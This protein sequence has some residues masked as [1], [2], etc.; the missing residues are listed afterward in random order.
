MNKKYNLDIF[1]NNISTLKDTSIDKSPDSN[2]IVTIEYM[3]ESK[4]EVV[5]FD[6]VKEEYIKKFK[7]AEMIKSIDALIVEK[8]LEVFVEFKNGDISYYKNSK[9]DSDD[10]SEHCLKNNILYDIEW[11]IRDSLLIYC[12]LLKKNISYTREKTDFILVYNE[13]K[14]KNKAR[15]DM[16]KS[17]NRLSKKE[18]EL[19]KWGFGK[20]KF[21]FRNVHTYTQKEFESY[22]KKT[23]I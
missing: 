6:K 19:V 2:G 16:K 11:K 23:I 5:N 1:E 18:D 20:Y 12:D 3:T 7:E 8:D 13:F 15:D 10:L 21:F 4:L 9:K 14:N 17:I 22:I